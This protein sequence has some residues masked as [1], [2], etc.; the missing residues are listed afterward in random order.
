MDH[1]S[2]NYAKHSSKNPLQRW[3]IKTFHANVIHLLLRTSPKNIF[4][5]GCG[6]GFS[7]IQIISA[8]QSEFIGMDIDIKSSLLARKDCSS[9]FFLQGDIKNSPFKDSVFDL[10]VSLEVLEHIENPLSAL[11]ELCRVSRKWLI[12]SVPNEPFFCLA[13][14][15]RGK[16]LKQWGN[17]PGH[18][19]HWTKRSF[20]H[21][22][23][24]RCVV[25]EKTLSFP[26]IIL[27]CKIK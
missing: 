27:L 7:S 12:L 10:V 26:W 22:V 20:V 19:N 24:R 15:L 25:I 18:I 17:D 14:F 5:A 6:E 13:N 23:E 9:G 3:L 11:D 1:K 21:F 8:I 2:D 16:N 4:E